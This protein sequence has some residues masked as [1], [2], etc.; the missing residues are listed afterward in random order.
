M[1]A[2]CYVDGRS[3]GWV[4]NRAHHADLGGA[5]PGSIP[6]DATEIQQEGLRIPPVRLTAEVRAVIVA[7]SRT[8]DERRGDLDAQSGPTSSA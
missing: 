7:S 2:P 3:S 6:A 8:P 5:A 1:V 4:A